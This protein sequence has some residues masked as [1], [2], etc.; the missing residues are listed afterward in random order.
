[1]LCG[2]P[3]FNGESDKEIME[4]VKLGSYNF[5]APEWSEVSDEAQRLISK[6]LEYDPEK[7]YTAMQV[8]NDPWFKL[9]L[10]EDTFEKPLMISALE[11]LRQ[12][13]VKI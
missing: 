11:N 2:S 4:R 1:M 6:M 10:G 8:L 7:R 3:P 9:V 12:F 13:R 5:D